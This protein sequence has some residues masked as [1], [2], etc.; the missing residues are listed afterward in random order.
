METIN[1]ASDNNNSQVKKIS[2][3]IFVLMRGSQTYVLNITYND[4]ILNINVKRSFFGYEAN[5][6]L[7]ELHAIENFFSKYDSLKDIFEE[8]TIKLDAQS[9][10]FNE[11]VGQFTLRFEFIVGLNDDTF[12]EVKSAFVLTLKKIPAKNMDELV[13]LM[14]KI[15]I[16]NNES[17]KELKHQTMEKFAKQEETISNLNKQ[18]LMYEVVYL[19][20]NQLEQSRIVKT[21]E[22]EQ[23][24]T[25]IGE[26]KYNRVYFK[27]LY[28]ATEHGV[29]AR[30]FH[31]RCDNKVS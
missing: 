9:V 11:E 27:L 1:N 2:E 19:N 22:V 26:T 7:G 12:E 14:G 30:D 10:E 21:D 13:D 23:M 17:I 5:Y 25:W 6:T 8:L 20:P 29:G 24:K 15:I 3:N 16:G 28:R 18:C 4:Q 31:Y